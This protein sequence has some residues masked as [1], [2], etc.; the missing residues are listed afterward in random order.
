MIGFSTSRDVDEVDDEHQGLAALDDATCAA[1]AAAEIGRD[2]EP[3]PAADAHPADALIPAGDHLA[4]AEPEVEGLVAVPARVE[5]L[6]V[7]PG[8]AD[9]VD[10]DTRPTRRL[11]AVSDDLVLDDE[12]GRRLSGRDGDVR[13]AARGHAP[14]VPARD[15]TIPARSSSAS[16]RASS[17]GVAGIIGSRCSLFGST[18]MRRIMY[19]TGIGLVSQKTARFSS[20]SRW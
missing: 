16:R 7:A 18:P 13:L 17:S 2:R 1:T 8:D 9:V 6:S 12:I 5:L 20:N 15:Q 14:T 10:D 3:A 19:L 11:R 4:A